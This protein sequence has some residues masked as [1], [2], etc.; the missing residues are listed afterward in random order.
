MV[1]SF[2]RRHVNYGLIISVVFPQ[3]K[4]QKQK[5]KPKKDTVIQQV[6]SIRVQ[7]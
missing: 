7:H 6:L 4:K 3:K 2:S 1:D 5:T